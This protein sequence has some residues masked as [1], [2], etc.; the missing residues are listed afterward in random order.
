V[1][2][3]FQKV[4]SAKQGSLLLDMV[5]FDWNRGIEPS[6]SLVNR[7]ARMNKEVHN[8]HALL[9]KKGAVHRMPK[10]L[11][12]QSALAEMYLK[13]SAEERKEPI[14]S[15][16]FISEKTALIRGVQLRVTYWKVHKTNSDQW[17][18][19]VLAFDARQPKNAWPFF[20][21]SSRNVVIDE[22]EDAVAELDKEYLYMEELNR[23]FVNFGMGSTDFDVHWY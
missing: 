23:E 14:D 19:H 20:I 9:W 10:S 22:D 8:L 12:S 21:E 18:G 13:R 17:L 1:A 15:V 7:L 3:F 16:I 4:Y 6:D 5:E 2:A 11:T